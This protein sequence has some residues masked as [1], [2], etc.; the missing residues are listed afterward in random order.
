MAKDY[1]EILGVD[2]SASPE[3]IKKAYRRLA[4]QHHPDKAGGN[5]AKFKEINEAYQ[6]LGDTSKRS[7]Y[8]QFGANFEQGGANGF[9]GFDF[10]GAGFGGINDIF[11]QFFRGGATN[12]T[13]QR[14]VRRGD[15][16]GIDVT[17]SFAESARDIT[18]EVNLRMY[19]AC[20]HCHGNGAEP[21][22]KIETCRTCQGTGT[23]TT[24]RQT[25]FGSFAQSSVCPDCHGDGKKA[26]TVCHKCHGEGRELTNRKLDIKIPAGIANQQTIEISGKGEIPPRGGL[27]GNLY[28]NVHVV[29]HPRLRRDGRNVRLAESI[30]F[31][32][33][34]LGT[35]LS[36]PTLT[37]EEKI[38]IPAG[39]QPGTEIRLN[40]LGFPAIHSTTKGD[41]I[42]TIQVEIPRKLTRHQK[43]LLQE[44]EKSPTKKHRLF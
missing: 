18:K 42:V 17:I 16:I 36:V 12:R 38:D 21:G 4:H 34:A 23:V 31:T 10:S 30:S 24:T 26:V 15:D 7:Q 22:T 43:E 39:T 44:F 33:A 32:A 19:Q 25:M 8:D 20:S 11:E 13:Q 6:V 40:G 35:S 14:S 27:P 5:E 37:G 9:G 1:Y 3:A 29:P 41:Q 2:R 28:V